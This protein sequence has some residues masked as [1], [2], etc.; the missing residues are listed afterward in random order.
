MKYVKERFVPVR[1]L[2][3]AETK[4]LDPLS[5]LFKSKNQCR[6]RHRFFAVASE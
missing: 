6:P 5:L 4:R 1:K 2:L 3:E